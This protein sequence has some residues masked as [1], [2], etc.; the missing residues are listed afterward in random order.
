MTEQDFLKLSLKV[1][2]KISKEEK[3]ELGLTGFV[4]EKTRWVVERSNAWVERCRS[5][6]KNLDRTL[7]NANARLM[8]E[9]LAAN[10]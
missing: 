2:P 4:T 10:S 8:L 5:L 9:R 6:V 3:K 1:S 7:E